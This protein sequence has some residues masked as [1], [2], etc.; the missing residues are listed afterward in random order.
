MPDRHERATRESAP[1]LR[2]EQELRYRLAAP[3]IHGA[4]LWA[5]LG[6]GSG[7]AAARALEGRSAERTVLVD[8]GDG[9]IE[10]AS[11]EL[12]GDLRTVRA[13]LS[14]ADD[15][16]RVRAQLLEVAGDGTRV[17]TC[18]DTIERVQA[19]PALVGL[20]TELAEDDG[21]TVLLS[22]PN[23]AFWHDGETEPHTTWG[24]GA[25][26][27][28]RSLVPADHLVVRQLPLRGSSLAGEGVVAVQE[29]AL[30]ADPDGVPSHFIIVFGPAREQLALGAAVV[31]A[32]LDEE[33]HHD[34]RRDAELAYLRSEVDALRAEAGRPSQAP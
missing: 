5:D 6:C 34:R 20:L 29:V 17:V 4:A 21:F 33:R 24:E 30:S 19:F 13:D 1:A 7:V 18:F 2:V 8:S 9:A 25:F 31:Q 26:E 12:A 16:A 28:L 27:E 22:A 32:D 14:S 23:D 10:D 15:L 11:R 3:L